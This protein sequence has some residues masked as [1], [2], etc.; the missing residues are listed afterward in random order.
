ME[1]HSYNYWLALIVGVCVGALATWLVIRAAS[2]YQ[3]RDYSGL[4]HHAKVHTFRIA[5]AAAA[6]LLIIAGFVLSPG[7]DQ[8][9]ACEISVTV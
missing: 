1:R 4:K 7:M 9:G 2:V 3:R 6:W 5:T 8:M